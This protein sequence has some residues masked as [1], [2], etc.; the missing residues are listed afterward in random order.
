M[1]TTPVPLAF[2]DT[3]RLYAD[4][5]ASVMKNRMLERTPTQEGQQVFL[6]RWAATDVKVLG[7]GPIRAT[8]SLTG[9]FNSALF[10][11]SGDKIYRYDP[12]GTTIAITGTLFGSPGAVSMVGVK[13]ADYERLFI[14]DGSHLQLYQGGSHATGTLTGTG[15]VADGDTVQI[16]SSWFKWSATIADGAGTLASP[17]VVL[18]GADLAADLTNLVKAISFTGVAGTDYSAN[19]GGQNGEVTAIVGDSS[20][21]TVVVTAISDLSD[22]NSIATTATGTAVSW[23]AATLSGGGVHGLSGVEVPDGLPPNSVATLK[24]YIVVTLDG[25]DKFFFIQPGEITIDPL[26]FATAESHPD[27]TWQVLAVGDTL[28]F[29]GSDSIEVWY[30]TGDSSAPFAP[31]AGRTYEI[32]AVEGTAV[33]IKGT[34]YL[35]GNDYIVYAVGGSPSRISDHGVEELIRK[36]LE[37]E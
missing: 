13:G 12:D 16:G 6:L 22:G 30:P 8:Y 18:R 29:V 19:L 37:A 11:A 5:P 3:E 15:H 26:D 20:E 9:L 24:S 1:A 33:N 23:G 7:G 25:T 34:V 27:S 36:T 14:A 32:G 2:T 28:W 17:W 21:T 35:V 4:L 10:V 31:V